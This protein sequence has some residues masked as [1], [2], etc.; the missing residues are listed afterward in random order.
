LKCLKL[1][2]MLIALSAQP[3]F[4]C[5]PP[6]QCDNFDLQVQIGVS[7]ITWTGRQVFSVVNC[8]GFAD[9][10]VNLFKM[11]NFRALF[12]VPFIVGAQIGYAYSTNMRVY[13]E[14]NYSQAR[15][16]NNTLFTSN[17]PLVTPAQSVH[18]TFENYRLFDAYIGWRY[19]FDCM[20]NISLFL[21]GKVGLVHHLATRLNS[22]VVSAPGVTPTDL[23]PATTTVHLFNRNTAVSGGFNIGIDYCLCNCWSIVVTGEVVANCGPKSNPNIALAVIAPFTASNVFLGGIQTELRFPI[24]A[25]I[26]YSF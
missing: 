3:L 2:S 18:L 15:Q 9:P 4:S 12:G 7:P 21:G 17:N 11:P 14:F 5:E 6:L 22:L 25:G 1:L 8:V 13:G 19:Y 16:K 24:T 10:V 26:R 23:L 20:C